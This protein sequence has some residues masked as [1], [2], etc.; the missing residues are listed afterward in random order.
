[1]VVHL[2]GANLQFRHLQ[3]LTTHFERTQTR[4]FALDMSM[5]RIQ[6]DW[7]S[8]NE[9]I[10]RLLGSNLVQYLDLGMNYLPALSSLDESLLVK[11]NFAKL[12]QRLSLALD[13]NSYTGI[14]DFDHWTKNARTFKREA[15]GITEFAED[16]EESW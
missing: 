9:I 7:T 5:N 6:T 15:Y 10:N 13:C 16:P 1:M 11:Q 14:A 12:G 2:A 8:L 4:V 3:L